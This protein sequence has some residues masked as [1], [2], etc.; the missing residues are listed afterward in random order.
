LFAREPTQRLA[1]AWLVAA[2]PSQG[3]SKLI[4][5]QVLSTLHV[6]LPS[7]EC[8]LVGILHFSLIVML[9]S[10]YI[11]AIM[12]S[13]ASKLPASSVMSMESVYSGLRMGL[14][15]TRMSFGDV[16]LSTPTTM[17]LLSLPMNH[18]LSLVHRLL[19]RGGLRPLFT[20]GTKF[21]M[22]E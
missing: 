9:A 21:A 20:C 4:I 12:V 7:R 2:D 13:M 11:P 16:F 15:H 1:L 18:F 14:S 5:G 8:L 3:L 10:L 6:P 22:R 17:R 19:G